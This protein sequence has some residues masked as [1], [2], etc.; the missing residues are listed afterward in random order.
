MKIDR[1]ETLVTS[2]KLVLTLGKG[3]RNLVKSRF[4]SR[5][6]MVKLGLAGLAKSAS[7]ILFMLLVITSHTLP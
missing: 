2:V 6:C 1:N 5:D 4:S 3:S 7:L